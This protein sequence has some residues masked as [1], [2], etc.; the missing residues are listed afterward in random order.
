[1]ALH[2]C[3]IHNSGYIHL[4]IGITL[5]VLHRERIHHGVYIHWN[6]GTTPMA[7][8]ITTIIT[9]NGLIRDIDMI[10]N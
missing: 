4:D 9:A 6:I 5:I 7:L 8:R 2:R 10:D 3:N 1:M